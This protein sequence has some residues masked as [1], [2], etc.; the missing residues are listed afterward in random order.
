MN[1]PISSMAIFTQWAEQWIKD[2]NRLIDAAK[3]GFDQTNNGSDISAS[4]TKGDRTAM[5]DMIRQFYPALHQFQSNSSE[6]TKANPQIKAAREICMAAVEVLKSVD[7]FYP[8]TETDILQGLQKFL[9]SVSFA[10]QGQWDEPVASIMGLRL[11]W[12]I[13]RYLLIFNGIATIG[14]LQKAL[15]LNLK[16]VK[17]G[18]SRR[19][20]IKNALYLYQHTQHEQPHRVLLVPTKELQ[21]GLYGVWSIATQEKSEF[22]IELNSAQALTLANYCAIR[23]L[24]DGK[25]VA[26][27]A[28]RE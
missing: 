24:P 18:A 11:G 12:V 1:Q 6:L 21:P 4:S 17:I 14:Q 9:R 7:F 22:Y 23:V 28:G 8:G 15:D 16:L 13:N 2:T 20:V 19:E 25:V 10:G 26:K 27:L 5:V 3:D